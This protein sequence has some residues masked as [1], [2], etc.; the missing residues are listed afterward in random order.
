MKR[1]LFGWLTLALLLGGA[2]QADYIYTTFDAPPIGGG[3]P[4]TNGTQAF[5]I[6]DADQIV[7]SYPQYV[8]KGRGVTQGFLFSGG[9]Y[10]RISVAGAVTWA[11]GISNSGLIVGYYQTGPVTGPFSGFLLSQGTYTTLRVPGSIS[12]QALGINQAGQI[13]G[14]YDGHGFL[15]SGGNYTTLDVPGSKSTNAAGISVSGQIVGNYTD[16]GSKSHGYLLSGGNFAMLDVPGSSSTAANGINGLGQIVGAYDNKHG[17]MLNNGLYTT[18]DVPG[19]TATFAEGI[20]DFGDIVG[21]YQVNGVNG[22]VHAFIATPTS[23]PVPEP[24]T[25]L[26]FAIGFVGMLGWACWRMWATE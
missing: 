2:V 16:T 6:N 5:G 22:D 26:L 19:S 8:N 7:G 14:N 20:D 4:P 24:A 21:Y 13:V 25:L 11:S 12:T 15:F 1:M 10:S 17:F 18:L 23:A 3:L 9:A